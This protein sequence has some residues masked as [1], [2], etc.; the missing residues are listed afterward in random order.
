[1]FIYLCEVVS[2]QVGKMAMTVVLTKLIESCQ[3]ILFCFCLILGNTSSQPKM[4]YLFIFLYLVVSL[5]FYHYT[6]FWSLDTEFL[7]HGAL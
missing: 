3:H 4:I 6:T 2:G 1:M 5:T 7:W